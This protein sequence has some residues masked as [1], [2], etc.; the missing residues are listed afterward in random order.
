MTE[1]DQHLRVLLVEPPAL[2]DRPLSK[3]LANDAWD[4]ALRR[5]VGAMV[6]ALTA[7]QFDVVLLDAALPGA[8][9]GE[10]WRQLR[11]PRAAPEFV[12]IGESEQPAAA[13]RGVALGAA[14]VLIRPY[15]GAQAGAQLRLA[16]ERRRARF[17]SWLLH[18]Q[19]SRPADVPDVVTQYAPMQ[20]VLSLVERVARGDTSVLITGEPGTGRT[21]MARLLHRFSLR[22]AEP[23]ITV[24]CAG[25][26]DDRLEVEL[27]G[28]D[29]GL[30]EHSRSGAPGLVE[31]ASG[32]TL[33]F[34]EIDAL[35]PKVQ[36]RL[37]RTLEL[38]SFYR[39]DGTQKVRADVR[40]IATSAPDMG[41]S[42]GE[43]LRGDL[44]YRINT[45]TIELPPLRERTCDIPVLARHFLDA[46][47]G[48]SAPRLSDEAVDAL[49]RH[50]WPGNVRELQQ[51]MHRV[52]LT[53]RDG[54]VRARDLALLRPLSDDAPA[55]RMDPLLPLHTMERMQIERVLR[56]VGWH[57]GRA[58]ELLGISPKT[59]YRKI[60]EYG[61][62]RP[63]G[64]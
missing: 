43:S 17:E 22:A 2:A 61:F 45:M 64:A 7:E 56:H 59:L 34:R 23:L 11:A 25:T 1:E 41:A 53:A 51:V 46:A 63:S 31:L 16:F 27:Y 15:E 5:D 39:V 6:E 60:R 40:V 54:V 52:L 57:Q 49:E 47:R 30:D 38:R 14:G 42:D 48:I 44:Y 19:L 3:A 21:L 9:D 20:A 37:L 24:D 18:A 36:G 28:K 35:G 29:P 4:V 13:L 50:P 10:L 26:L 55:T 8:L 33:V 62:R 12:I 32:G 58:A